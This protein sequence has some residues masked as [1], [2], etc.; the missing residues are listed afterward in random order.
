MVLYVAENK[1]I[2]TIPISDDFIQTKLSEILNEFSRGNNSI[3]KSKQLDE[4]INPRK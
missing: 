2:V 1:I 4:P 3:R